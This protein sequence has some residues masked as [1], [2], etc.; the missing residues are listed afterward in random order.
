MDGGSLYVNWTSNFLF[1]VQQLE[2]D[3]SISLGVKYLWA[4]LLA[5]VNIGVTVKQA[6]KNIQHMKFFFKN[7][8]NHKSKF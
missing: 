6:L 1:I 7:I 3:W 8:K 4:I 2:P 5:Y